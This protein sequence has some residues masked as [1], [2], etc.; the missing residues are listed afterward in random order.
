MGMQTFTAEAQMRGH[1]AAVSF[2]WDPE[3]APMQIDF[4]VACTAL[5]I[6]GHGVMPNDAPAIWLATAPVPWP[7]YAANWRLLQ[8]PRDPDNTVLIFCEGSLISAVMFHRSIL[9][10]L[11]QA[12]AEDINEVLENTAK[13]IDHLCE[14]AGGWTL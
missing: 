1:R 2:L 12:V 8:D 10:D 9:G 3:Y 7:K 14:L 6:T 5:N 11:A 13:Q 4:H